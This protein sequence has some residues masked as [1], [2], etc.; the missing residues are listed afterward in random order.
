MTDLAALAALQAENERL[1]KLLENHGI[2]G[3]SPQQGALV[4]RERESS[5]LSTADKV[6][7]FR[8]LFHGRTDVYPIRWEGK[9]LYSL[10]VRRSP[11]ARPESFT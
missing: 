4:A 3:Q 8:R 11:F 1:I 5:R 9:T 2:A 6:A 7:L 10:F